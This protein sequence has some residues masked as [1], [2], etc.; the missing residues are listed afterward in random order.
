MS[1]SD[2]NSTDLLPS[3]YD[4]DPLERGGEI[5]REGF[6]YQDHV[7]AGF[8]LEMLERADI[9]EVWFET[10]DDI[11]IIWD[12]GGATKVEF[13]QVKHENRASR[14]SIAALTT[15][16]K[17]AVEVNGK[18]EMEAAV[19][20]SLLEKSLSHSRC[21]E[22]TC[23]RIV[24]SFDVDGDLEVLKFTTENARRTDSTKELSDLT[25]ELTKRL[26]GIAAPDGTSIAEWVKRCYWDKKPETSDLIRLE[27]IYRL[28][29]IAKQRR[30]TLFQD[31][32][33][34][35]YQ[36]L[37]AKVSGAASA[38][39]EKDRMAKRITKADIEA[40]WNER[41]QEVNQVGSG[42]KTLAEKME[43]AG[44]PSDTI[45]TAEEIRTFYLT[46]RLDHDYVSAFTHKEAE[47]DVAA[48]L[49]YEKSRLD[50]GEL[51]EDGVRFHARCLERLQEISAKPYYSNKLVT[52]SF[53]QGYMYER[54]NRCVHRF[55]RARP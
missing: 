26:D 2:V 36:R 43:R 29:K 38:S 53:L 1:G 45:V 46:K 17:R 4:L 37:L 55:D 35:I 16:E 11:M 40:W 18:K 13:V 7:G 47:R 34:E 27:N 3:I 32:R 25:E 12:G 10:H 22:E 48:I 33:D 54:A 28:E 8:C 23:F 21:K 39:Y 6:I 9:I 19:G 31:H 30:Q 41:V 15:R 50:A 51:S 52:L 5:A 42:S 20:T 24:T 49:H 14:W 44:I